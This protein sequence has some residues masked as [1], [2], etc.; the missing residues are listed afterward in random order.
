MKILFNIG[1]PAQVHLFKNPILN[2]EKNGHKCKITTIDKDVPLYLLNAYNLNYEVVGKS[3]NTIVS[4]GI[5]LPKIEKQLY[6]IT[7]FFKPDILIGGV[8]N[9]YVAHIGKLTGKPSIVFDDTEHA[10]I[11][12]FLMD[13]FVDVVCTPSCY[14]KDLG[15]K[16]IR[17]NGYHELTYLHPNYF[18]PNS[19]VLDEIGLSKDKTFIVL[20]LVSW[21]ASHDVGQHGIR[22]KLDF[23]R[24]LEKHGKVLITS[25]GQLP[26]ELEKYK[27]KV[28][29]EKIHDLLYYA[30]LY[31]GEGAT[32]AVESA[33]LGTPSIYISSLVGKMGNLVELEQKYGLIYSYTEPHKAI[34][35]AVGLIKNPNLKKEWQNK[36]DILLKDKIDVTAFIVW[37]IENYPE[38]CKEAK[39]RHM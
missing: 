28:S 16:Q 37:L 10:K 25:E 13:R 11:E 21:A 14:K 39:E 36:K 15:K 6:K 38:S 7:R 1:H 4:K 5:E 17:Y 20:R 9:V 32:M 23:V 2:L 30:S 19:S 24:E 26:K 35:K 27:I 29:P 8:G 18:I 22:N 34:E 31:I 12:H 3:K 33:I